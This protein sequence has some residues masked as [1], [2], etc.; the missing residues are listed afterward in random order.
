M[1]YTIASQVISY[2]NISDHVVRKL[3]SELLHAI[4]L[5]IIIIIIVCL[6]LSGVLHF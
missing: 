6:S 2:Y 4:V 1:V 3:L 5:P